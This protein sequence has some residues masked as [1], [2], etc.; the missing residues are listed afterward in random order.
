MR[1]SG[2]DTKL[3]NPFLYAK[4]Q[5]LALAKREPKALK[6]KRAKLAK[7]ME[8]VNKLSPEVINECKHLI[9]NQEYESY[10]MDDTI[11]HYNYTVYKIKCI[12]C[13]KILDNWF[14]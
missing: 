12:Q 5:A 3:H 9:E 6:L 2:K 13:G 1:I 10:P 8:K 14:D 4:M 11:G 7:L